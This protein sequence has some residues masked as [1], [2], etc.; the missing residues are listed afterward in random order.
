MNAKQDGLGNHYGY[1]AVSTLN[2]VKSM[3]LRSSRNT[4]KSVG[5]KA[6]LESVL[7]LIR[8]IGSRGLWHGSQHSLT[9]TLSALRSGRPLIL[10]LQRVAQ[11]ITLKITDPSFSKQNQRSGCLLLSE[12]LIQTL[13]SRRSREGA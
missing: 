7:Y 4:I 9:R 3:R 5:T 12:G 2:G 10:T 1:Q 8:M 13:D 6:R 11:S